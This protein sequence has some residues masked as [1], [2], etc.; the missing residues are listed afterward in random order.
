[1]LA[2][3]TAGSATIAY[4][5][6]SAHGQEEVDELSKLTADA[7]K[8][9]HDKGV[10]EGEIKGLDEGM[11][12]TSS[13]FCGYAMSMAESSDKEA[14][15]LK[16]VNKKYGNNKTEISTD[17]KMVDDMNGFSQAIAREQCKAFTDEQIDKLVATQVKG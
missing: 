3:V 6:G 14:T 8:F 15:R 1:M 13:D 9:S 2:L 11:R 16:G 12:A 5:M 7:N 4:R 17:N 10:Y